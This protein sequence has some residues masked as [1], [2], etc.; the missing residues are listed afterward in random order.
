M[1]FK[2]FADTPQT[3]SNSG[4]SMGSGNFP[5]A[6]QYSVY[7]LT[8]DELQST[9][10]LGKDLGSMNLEDLLKNIWTAEESQ[11]VASSAGVGNLQREGSLTLPRTLSQK[12]VDELWRDFQKETTVSSK[13]VSGTE[14][15]NL[16]QSQSTLG[17]MTLEEFLVRAGVVRE[18]MQPTGSTN[19]VRFTGGISQ[20]STNNNGLNIAF[21]QPTQNPGLFSNQ[22]EEKN[23]L[24]VVSATS[25]QQKPNVAFA[26]PMQL[27]KNG[28]LASTAAREPVVSMLSPSVNTSTIVQGSVMQGG[29]KGLAGLHNGVALAKRGSPGNQLSPDMIAKKDQD[30]SSL[31]PSPYAF[32]DGGRGRRSCNS[33]EKV[34]ER[35]RKRMI[36]NRESAARSRARKQAYTLELEAEVEKLKEINEELQKKQAEFIEMQKDQLMEK[37]NMPWGNKLRCLRRTL[38]GPW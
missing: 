33:L 26:S 34:V 23:M 29:V 24:N 9:C 4:M 12:T 6:R 25:S 7:S 11:V 8:F 28:Q 17:E 31:S 32:G 3:E 13:D 37:M 20:P 1:N 10:G 36:K 14:W 35:R 16:G 15:P 19:D 27:G 18:D 38:T 30:T 2:N 5:L 22:F 21:Q